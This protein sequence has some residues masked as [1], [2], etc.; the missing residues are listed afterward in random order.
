MPGRHRQL[1]DGT[2]SMRNIGAEFLTVLPAYLKPR[3]SVADNTW[4]LGLPGHG[5]QAIRRTVAP[6]RMARGI[7]ATSSTTSSR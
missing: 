1:L 2:G 3:A 6:A 7:S 5:L 4:P